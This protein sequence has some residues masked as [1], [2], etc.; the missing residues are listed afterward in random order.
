MD[1]LDELMQQHRNAEQLIDRLAGTDPG[2]ERNSLVAELGD[3]LTFHMEIEETNVY[4]L[5][6]DHLGEDVA[7]EVEAD[8]DAVRAAIELLTEDIDAVEFDSTLAQLR[9]AL[10]KHVTREE[11][12]VFPQLRERA[13]DDVAALGVLDALEIEADEIDIEEEF[14]SDE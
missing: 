7:D 2:D 10:G 12:T 5:V 4:A 11:S 14:D 6:E 9:T 3:A 8:H 1:V 13:P